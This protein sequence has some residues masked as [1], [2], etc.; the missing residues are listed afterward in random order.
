MK[1][2]LVVVCCCLLFLCCYTNSID[3]VYSLLSMNSLTDRS[4]RRKRRV[5]HHKSIYHTIKSKCKIQN[6]IITSILIWI[7]VSIYFVGSIRGGGYIDG[8][9]I[10]QHLRGGVSSK[11]DNVWIKPD[12]Q[13]FVSFY[14]N[15]I[16]C[17]CWCTFSLIISP[18]TLH[19][20]HTI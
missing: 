3:T 10:R 13:P 20:I 2:I 6:I 4:P 5:R 14:C 19:T 9:G 18:H 17:L 11:Y 8:M 7:I 12:S 15:Y 1:I 16:V